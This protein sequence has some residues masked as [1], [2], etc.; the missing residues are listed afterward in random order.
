MH[1]VIILNWFFPKYV[2]GFLLSLTEFC[3]GNTQEGAWV[4]RNGYFAELFKNNA[5]QNKS[6]KDKEG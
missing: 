5:A 3:Q 4:K 6:Q 2:V 1:E